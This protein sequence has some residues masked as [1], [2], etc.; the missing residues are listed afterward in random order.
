MLRKATYTFSD[1]EEIKVLGLD[2]IVQKDA[3]C[4][5]MLSKERSNSREGEGGLGMGI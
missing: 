5:E 2:Q 1:E 4:Y 3:R